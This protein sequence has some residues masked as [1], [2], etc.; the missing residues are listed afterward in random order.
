VRNAIHHELTQAYSTP[1]WYD[2][3]SLGAYHKDKI[4]EAKANAGL[5]AT[6]GKVIAEL[7]FSFWT[8]LIAKQY[9]ASLWTPYLRKAFPNTSL[10]RGRVFFRLETIKHLRNRLA[11]HERIL[12]SRGELWAGYQRYIKLSD[13]SECAEWICP[14]TARWLMAKFR[15]REAGMIL[16][17]VMTMGVNLV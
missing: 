14:D 3:A 4:K 11:H 8:G 2:S 13:I 1:R 10:S 5:N 12:T 16:L 9:H 6:P 17:R 7:S 15:Y